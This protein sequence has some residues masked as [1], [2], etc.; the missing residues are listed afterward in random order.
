VTTSPDPAG[1]LTSASPE[2]I[3]DDPGDGQDPGGPSPATM[4]AELRE[5]GHNPPPRGRLGPDW[6]ALWESGESAGAPGEDLEGAAVTGDDFPEDHA[7]QVTGEAAPRKP[8]AKTWRERLTGPKNAPKGGKGRHDSGRTRSGPRTRAPKHERVPLD[9]L[10]ESVWAALGRWTAPVDAALSRC[11]VLQAPVSGM[12]AEDMIRGT[13]VDRPLQYVAR[14]QAK[15]NLAA[16]LLGM[17]VGIIMLEH[18]QTLPDRQ[19]LLREA[20]ILPALRECAVSYIEIAGDKLLERAKRDAER[21][22]LYDQA[23][24]IIAHLLYGAP[25][26]D[27]LG[28]AGQAAGDPGAWAAAV[29][30]EQDQAAGQAQAEAA[31]GAYSGFMAPPV[32]P[33]PAPQYAHPYAQLVPRR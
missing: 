10:G 32:H 26:G 7:H 12:M 22:P 23:D 17:P 1:L 3:G 8:R 33:Q 14:A 18:A 9:R 27:D 20:V 15:A 6:V 24:A 4:R 31:P 19:R 30:D 28:A 21:A 29:A 16:A 2:P 11:F 25:L 5:R 13:P